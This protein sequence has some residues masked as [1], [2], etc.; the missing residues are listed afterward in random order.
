MANIRRG[1]ARNHTAGNYPMIRIITICM[2]LL[3]MVIA[4]TAIR[5]EGP[6]QHAEALKLSPELMGLLQAEM[7]EI[8]IGIQRVPVA[9][10][11]GDWKILAQT[12]ESIRASYIMNKALTKEQAETL[13]SSLPERF[14]Q[15]DSDFHNRAGALAHAAEAKDFE[16]ASYHY[17]RL[18]ESCAQCHALYAQTRFPGFGPVEA[19]GHQH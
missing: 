8:S 4:A 6:E 10:A 11:E 3:S 12:G 1:L 7:R 13:E 19:H 9:I 18:L 15:I 2:L 14:K 16:L 5:A 17:S